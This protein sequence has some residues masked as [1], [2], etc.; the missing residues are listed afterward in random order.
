MSVATVFLM[1]FAPQLIGIFN[2][3]PEFLELAVPAMRI[4]IAMLPVIGLAI[5]TTSVFQGMGRG[6]TVLFL[7][8]SRQLIFFIPA[9]YIMAHFWGLTG[10]WISMP[11]SDLCGVFVAVV[12]LVIVFRKMRKHPNWQE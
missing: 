1:I 12:W 9:M 8:L 3:E 11:F 4:M 6:L 2:Q 10:V 7:S 5:G